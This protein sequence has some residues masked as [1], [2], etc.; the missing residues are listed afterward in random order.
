MAAV[1][2]A[3][4]LSYATRSLWSGSPAREPRST[5][6]AA[7][8]ATAPASASS[9]AREQARRALELVQAL[10][11]TREDFA[12]AD[13]FAQ[14]ALKLDATD[15]LVW[16]MAAQVHAAFIYRGWD[17]SPERREQNRSTAER[18]MRLAPNSPEA[19]LAQAGAWNTLGI[20][21][22]ETEKLL[23]EVVA[24][25]PDDKAALRFLA[26]TVM[27]N[28]RFD[29]CLALNE[30]AAALPGGDPLALFNNARY[31]WQ[32][33]RSE[34]A[35][36]ALERSLAQRPFNS[37]L[38][39]KA[40][41]EIFRRGDL[42]SAEA[43]LARIPQSSLLEDRANYVSGL[44]PYYR[45]DAEGA[46]KA[47]GVL[48]REYYSDFMFD[49]P[50]GMLIGLA[51]E[52]GGRPAA[53]EAEWRAALRTVEK[54]LATAPNKPE[55]L[56][57]K[58]YLLACLGEKAAAEE[59]LRTY[60]QLV[61]ERPTPGTPM[62]FELALLYARLGRL[63]EVFASFPSRSLTRILLDPRF[64]ALRADP[65]F[66]PYRE[67]SPPVPATLTATDRNSVAVLAFANLSDD[68]ANEY[69]S[70]GISEELLNVLAQVPGL[71]VTARTS[72]FHFKG[73]DTPIPEI[74]RQLGVAY[75]VEGSVRKAG[76]KVR[77]T[78]Q[79]IKAADGFHVWSDTFTRDLKDIFAVQD[80]IAGL[81][82]AQ[83]SL[84]LGEGSAAPAAPVDPHAFELYVEARQAWNLR[85]E[86]GFT[87]AETLLRQALALAPRFAR[88]HAALA[89]VWYFQAVNRG[90]TGTF[91]RP[92]P[93]EFAR[94][95]AKIREALALDPRSAEAH[96]S[97]GNVLFSSWKFAEAEQAYRQ[98][99]ALNPNYA[100]AHQWLAALLGYDG[101]MDEALAEIAR[102][103]E[104]DPLSSR[105]ADNHG[106]LL[107][108]AGRYPQ[109]L[110]M[111]E[112]AISLQPSN[113]QAVCYRTLMLAYLGRSAEAVSL[114]R[115]LP[116]SQAV[117]PS[118]QFEVFLK[119]GLRAEA[120]ALL[121][122][123][124]QG[125]FWHQS[126]P[127]VLLGRTQEAL[128][129]LDPATCTTPGIFLVSGFD[130]LD[131]EPAF[132]KF[133]A[134]IGQTE[135]RARIRAWRLSHPAESPAR[136]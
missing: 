54:R 35:F 129:L 38:V 58:S 107:F 133:I 25:R 44:I 43:A 16:A 106:F 24:A 26:V 4:G 6:P 128:A 130:R 121:P 95:L 18:A 96:A 80:E 32:R 123:A 19:K 28:G 117:T 132:R 5:P 65:R 74:A 135:A 7:P 110:A 115:Q 90:V 88:A 20:N 27:I 68:K 45:R 15:G 89:D 112:R 134:T 105:I 67:S 47:W 84:K 63:D 104:L 81:V 100:S 48:P 22:A 23:R 91:A 51:Y 94:V 60:L 59:C 120:E 92:D 116:A 113:L 64:D 49:G 126:Y 82:A 86:E 119:A 56:Y 39:L 125:S 75:V 52:L 17:T 46:L 33:G 77:I 103:M 42:A 69:F 97:L 53:A 21:R 124:M 29:E 93:P 102:A 71:K 61:N 37:S 83:L 87:R 2:I 98:A 40:V 31:L 72:S 1:G 114:A 41:M 79:L 99:I 8:E 122:A 76:D 10:E 3:A 12:L 13:D 9:P 85:N 11:A 101:R 34:E 73:K 30:R 62:S 78:A 70:D 109:A 118:F 55:R 131:A 14:R 136:P 57:E 111:F 66:A 127:L 36:A 50:K 108:L